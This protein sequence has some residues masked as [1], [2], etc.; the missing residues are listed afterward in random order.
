MCF[1]PISFWFPFFFPFN[2]CF[3]LDL[4]QKETNYVESNKKRE[5]DA[6]VHPLHLLL[7]LYLTILE[8]LPN[9]A[10]F[11]TPPPFPPVSP[12][13]TET[14]IIATAEGKWTHDAG[15]RE[16]DQNWPST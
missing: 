16:R 13:K 14:L 8:F 12:T 3:R 1:Y 2:V 10:S 11:H 5:N 9:P 15:K 7:L 4:K 6:L